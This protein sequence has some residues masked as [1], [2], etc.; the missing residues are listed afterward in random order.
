[1]GVRHPLYIYNQEKRRKFK[2]PDQ[3]FRTTTEMLKEFAWLGEQ[4]A[5]D[6]VIKNTRQIADMI[7]EVKPV[8]DR[9]YPP[10][11]EGS[12]QKLT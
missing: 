8:K 5:Y 2:A 4:R 10:D 9:L 3:H 11:I 6:M 12:D 7:G 1:G